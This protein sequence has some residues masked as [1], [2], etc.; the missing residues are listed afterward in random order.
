MG[1]TASRD[2]V[3]WGMRPD[4][5]FEY[6]VVRTEPGL[7]QSGENNGMVGLGYFRNAADL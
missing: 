5:N 3:S 6:S 1:A 7:P 4:P 2:Q